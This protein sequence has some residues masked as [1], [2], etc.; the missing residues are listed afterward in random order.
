MSTNHKIFTII[1]ILAPIIAWTV[2]LGIYAFDNPDSPAWYGI[3]DGKP[4]LF[5]NHELESVELLDIHRRF[6]S[7]FLWGF[8]H[9]LA[10][11]LLF[12]CVKVC[13]AL[14]P[15]LGECSQILAICSYGCSTVAWWVT[16]I[17]WRFRPDGAF[18][19]GDKFSV[20]VDGDETTL[21]A[22]PLLV[23]AKS[24]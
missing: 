12:L 5:E 15:K 22:D 21:E 10:P 11:W 1:F 7:W 8:I 3:V 20:L 13:T 9:A 2:Y 17:V 4:G 23:Q 6:A 18:A 16:G 19:S 24:G 14:S